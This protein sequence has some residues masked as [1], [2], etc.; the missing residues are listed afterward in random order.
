MSFILFI[1]KISNLD[2]KTSVI[3]VSYWLSALHVSNKKSL[4][5]K[6]EKGFEKTDKEKQGRMTVTIVIMFTKGRMK[7]DLLTRWHSSDSNKR[8]AVVG[9][10]MREIMNEIESEVALLLKG[11]FIKSALLLIAFDFYFSNE[12]L[13]E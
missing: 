12:T 7:R 3:G 2:L 13:T 5:K 4:N 1:K 6:G 10:I 11:N 9:N 8:R